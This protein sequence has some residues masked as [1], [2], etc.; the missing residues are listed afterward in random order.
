MVRVRRG[1][2]ALVGVRVRCGAEVLRV[3]DVR[4]CGGCVEGVWRM[5]GHSTPHPHLREANA[6]SESPMLEP[7]S[8]YT[9]SQVDAPG[10]RAP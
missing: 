1:A 8:R 3:A 10:G 5:C 6:W 4:V 2:E 9:S 7:T